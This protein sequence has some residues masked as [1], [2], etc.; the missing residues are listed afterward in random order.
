M[1]YTQQSYCHAHTLTMGTHH[2]CNRRLR[3]SG[4]RVNIA[5][6][7]LCKTCEMIDKTT[8]SAV[9]FSSPHSY[10]NAPAKVYVD[11]LLKLT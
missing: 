2:G 9:R 7:G 3:R 1:F 4:T 11:M 5:H 6:K 8:T 10:D